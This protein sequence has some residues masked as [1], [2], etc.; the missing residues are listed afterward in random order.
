MRP[1]EKKGIETKAGGDHDFAAV[2]KAS[3]ELWSEDDLKD[4]DRHKFTVWSL[5]HQ[6]GRRALNPLPQPSL[7]MRQQMRAA[8]PKHPKGRGRSLTRRPLPRGNFRRT[9]Q[10]YYES[11]ASSG[12]DLTEEMVE[13]AAHV[14]DRAEAE[15]WNSEEAHYA[16]GEE[17]VAEEEIS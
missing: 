7:G 9:D 10:A 3:V 11:D 13:L 17:A 1:Q 2:C 6:K 5:P 15:G 14:L 8:K 4:Y 12:E 16:E